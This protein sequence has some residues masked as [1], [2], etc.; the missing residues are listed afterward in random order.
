MSEQNEQNQQAEQSQQAEQPQTEQ[1]HTDLEREL[2]QLGERMQEAMNSA[3]NSEAARNIQRDISTAFND[4]GKQVQTTFHSV[5]EK[6]EVRNLSE[7]GQEA[8]SQVQQSQVI[9]DFQ[10][11]LATGVSKLNEQLGVFIQRMQQGSTE[12]GT[13]TEKQS[14][15][16]P[17]QSIPIEE[18]DEGTPVTG[19]TTHLDPDKQ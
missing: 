3:I 13:T 8:V 16:P 4:I 17:V 2:R 9:K 12:A 10:E 7:R 1:V 18:M 11:T 14:D 15:N 19:E 6:P 5:W